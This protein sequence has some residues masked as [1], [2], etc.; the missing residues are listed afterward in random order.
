MKFL[1]SGIVYAFLF[2]SFIASVTKADVDDLFVD[3]RDAADGQI[4]V[5]RPVDYSASYKDRRQT[6]GVLF[7]IYQEKYYPLDYFSLFEDKFIDQIIDGRTINL[8]GFEIGYKYNF[9]LG[10]IGLLAGYSQGHSEA[11]GT[12]NIWV[13]RTLVAANIAFDNFFNEPWVVPYAQVGIAKFGIEEGNTGQGFKSSSA[14]NVPNYKLGLLFQL[15]WIEGA[16]DPSSH[17]DALRSSGLE[18]TFLDIYYSGHLQSSAA[19]PSETPH[20][21]GEP[22]MRSTDELGLGIKMEF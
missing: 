5:E 13:K 3:E 14:N 10:S 15:N 18:N 2:I 19:I 11:P 22:N 4:T 17:V 9:S 1:I 20:V 12:R 16:I 7:S 8:L 21:V 6:H